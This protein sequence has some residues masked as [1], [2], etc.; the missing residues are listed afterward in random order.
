MNANSASS[1]VDLTPDEANA[2]S[3]PVV[4]VVGN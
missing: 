3:H 1:G 4:V 2:L